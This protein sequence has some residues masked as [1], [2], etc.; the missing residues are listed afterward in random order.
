MRRDAGLINE[1]LHADIESTT[2]YSKFSHNLGTF[3]GLDLTINNSFNKN[4][5]FSNGIQPN[6]YDA[7]RFFEGPGIG[8]AQLA[9]SDRYTDLTNQ[10]DIT[11]TYDAGFAKQTLKV[12]YDFQRGD[13]LF[14]SSLNFEDRAIV[15][16]INL[17]P[18]QPL[19]R[20]DELYFGFDTKY[21]TQG[22]YFLDKIDTL[23]NRLHI[24]GMVR[25]DWFLQSL[26]QN[27]FNQVG[28]D[29]VLSY[30]VEK[31]RASTLSWTAGAA[32]DVTDWLT[33]Y[34]SRNTGFKANPI[35]RSGVLPPQYSDQA[36]AGLR[37]FWFD[38]RLTVSG[39]F[40]DIALTN[41][42]VPDPFDIERARYILVEGQKNRG[43]EVEAQGEILPGLNLIASYGFVNATYSGKVNGGAPASGIPKNTFSTWITYTVQDS[44]YA[45]LTFGFGSRSLTD[46][47]INEFTG[48]L[49]KVPG[50]TV[51]NAMIGYEKDDYSISLKIN[52]LTNEYYF[53]PSYLGDYVGVGQGRSALLTARYKF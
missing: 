44:P 14:K 38:K 9:R 16:S 18:R 8:A 23:D 17:I 40:F 52:N 3:G 20:P 7:N 26:G 29:F 35:S 51:F 53:Q 39:A 12:G 37:T 48:V 45:G 50:Y 27:Q 10:F 1:R 4:W 5:S 22:V 15:Q 41:V 13:Q 30:G 2:I 25:N 47:I 36:E 43:F 11:G 28:D 34:G 19:F 21:T 46:S 6:I 32:F 49:Y 31:N 33:V 42:A 24:L